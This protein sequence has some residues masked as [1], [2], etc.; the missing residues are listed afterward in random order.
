M[1]KSASARSNAPCFYFFKGNIVFVFVFVSS[2]SD[3]MYMLSFFSGSPL[4]MYFTLH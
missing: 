2:H 3:F 1:T 4:V